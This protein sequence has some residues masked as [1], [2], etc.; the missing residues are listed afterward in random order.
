MSPLETNPAIDS[1]NRTTLLARESLYR[2]LAAALSDPRNPIFRLVLT[3]ENQTVAVQAADLLRE[4]AIREP[5]PLGLA[6]QFTEQAD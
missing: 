5:V 2:F 1:D 4:R 3:A 6:T